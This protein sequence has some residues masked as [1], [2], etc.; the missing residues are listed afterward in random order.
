MNDDESLFKKTPGSQQDRA[1]GLT[2][3]EVLQ[4]MTAL[5][6]CDRNKA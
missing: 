1:D 6:R 4:Y 3:R 5:V 2:V